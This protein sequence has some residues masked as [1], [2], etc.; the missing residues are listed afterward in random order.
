MGFNFPVYTSICAGTLCVL[1][2]VRAV[3]STRVSPESA[4]RSGA[5]A[6]DISPLFLIALGMLEVSDY[7]RFFVGVLGLAFV[8]GSLAMAAEARPAS[9][10]SVTARAGAVSRIV[11]TAIAGLALTY[12]ASSQFA[13]W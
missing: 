6:S 12:R 1:A 2:A 13:H 7:S 5:T 11:V 8:V 3:P 10:D 4:D 9:P